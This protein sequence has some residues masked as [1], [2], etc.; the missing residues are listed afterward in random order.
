MSRGLGV[1]QRRILD[2]LDAAKAVT[3]NQRYPGAEWHAGHYWIRVM[4]DRTPLPRLVTLPAGVYDLRCSAAFLARAD[5][6]LDSGHP[7]MSF[8]ACFSRACTHLEARGLLRRLRHVPVASVWTGGSE[9]V[10]AGHDQLWRGFD[11][12]YRQLRFVL[13]RAKEDELALSLRQE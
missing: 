2:T 10:L 1:M 11:W 12:P 6:R 3:E 7:T 5:G 13:L 4:A 9:V 8:S